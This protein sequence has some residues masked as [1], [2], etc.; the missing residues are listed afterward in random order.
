MKTL[1][2]EYKLDGGWAIKI[3]YEDKRIAIWTDKD[4]IHFGFKEVEKFTKNFIEV[5]EFLKGKI[6]Q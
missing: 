6:G 5:K 1:K 4:F 2:E 3:D